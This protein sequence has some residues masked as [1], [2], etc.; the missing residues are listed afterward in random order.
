[1]TVDIGILVVIAGVA[2][3]MGIWIGKSTE[4]MALDTK[5]QTEEMPDE[6]ERTME[7]RMGQRRDT[8]LANRYLRMPSA[9]RRPVR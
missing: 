6:Q 4:R 3:F 5:R 8:A 2:L 1:M 9:V 7:R